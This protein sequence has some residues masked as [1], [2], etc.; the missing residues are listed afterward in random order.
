MMIAKCKFMP[1]DI[2]FLRY[3]KLNYKIQKYTNVLANVRRSEPLS[4]MFHAAHV[5]Y[6]QFQKSGI[7]S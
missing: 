3:F 6:A 1:L 5:H 4:Y 7:F 2:V